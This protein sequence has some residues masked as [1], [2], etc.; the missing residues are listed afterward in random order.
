MKKL[1][2][3]LLVA[4][5]SVCAGC[6]VIP[7]QPYET[8]QEITTEDGTVYPAGTPVY[9]DAEGE[10][11]FDTHSP[12]GEPYERLTEDNVEKVEKIAVQAEEGA[13]QIPFGIGGIAGLIVGIAGSAAVAGLRRKR[14]HD[15]AEVEGKLKGKK[16][17]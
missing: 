7:Q 3:T 1:F 10:P 12:D 6:N 9:V 11:T 2:L 8:T 4:T 16:K 13:S 5:L 14:E 15:R 17:T